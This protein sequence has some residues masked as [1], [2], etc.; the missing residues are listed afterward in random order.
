MEY[1]STL[2]DKTNFQ[3]E[4]ESF[5]VAMQ[6]C[7]SG[8]PG[9]A[10]SHS[11]GLESALMHGLVRRDSTSFSSYAAIYLE[12]YC[13]QF[14]PILLQS[15]NVKLSESTLSD[16][17]N[18]DELCHISL[19]NEVSRRASISQGKCFLRVVTEAFASHEISLSALN[20]ATLK[21][22]Y[23]TSDGKAG[24]LY[25]HY[26]PIFGAICRILG[27]PYSLS[28]RMFMRCVIR[29]MVSA[30]ARLNIIGPLEGSRIQV[31]FSTVIED[32]LH[33]RSLLKD[34]QNL[35]S[36]VQ[37]CPILEILQSRHDQL[38]SRLFNS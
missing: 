30:A 25:G 32:M 3:I 5:W 31:I 9:G 28:E 11:G 6:L 21:G 37:T 2:T 12:Q 34:K 14:L 38:Y 16:Y 17:A 29:D 36:P 22:L 23:E 10:F 24:V 1:S 19:A 35:E 18:I 27:F 13:N 26:A 7:D 4:A 8:F 33:K 20:T 15:H